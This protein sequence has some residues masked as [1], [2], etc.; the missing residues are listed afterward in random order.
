MWYLARVEKE[1]GKNLKFLRSGKGDEFISREF[2]T[3][4]DDRGIKI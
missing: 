1:I 3:F 2:N 4:C